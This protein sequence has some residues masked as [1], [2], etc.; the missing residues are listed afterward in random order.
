MQNYK[1]T[2]MGQ[3]LCIGINTKISIER[4]SCRGSD[5]TDEEIKETMK[6]HMVNEELYDLT[7]TENE[8]VYSLKKEVAKQDW[9]RMLKEFYRIRY[10]ET[11][12]E[13]DYEKLIEVLSQ[14][15]SLDEWLEVGRKGMFCYYKMKRRPYYLCIG[16]WQSLYRMDIEGIILSFDGKIIMECYNRLFQFFTQSIRERL[17]RYKLAQALQVYIYG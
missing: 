5:A 3:Y 7:E 1:K 14:K 17:K 4:K 10:T 2:Y 9:I 8:L 12:E 11:G 16:K 15:N 6:Q 13:K